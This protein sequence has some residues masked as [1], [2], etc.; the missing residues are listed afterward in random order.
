MM[1][2]AAEGDSG[3]TGGSNIDRGALFEA[4]HALFEAVAE[5][6]PL[7]VVVEDLHWADQSTR[8][9]M[10]FLFTRP[11]SQPVALVASLPLRRPAPQ[12]PPPRQGR[13]VVPAAGRAPDVRWTR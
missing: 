4:V 3:S 10:S 7:V 12:A 2:D 6:Q 5:R 13:R 1:D 9:L 11:F 8:D